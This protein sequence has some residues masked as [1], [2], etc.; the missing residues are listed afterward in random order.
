LPT[1]PPSPRGRALADEPGAAQAQ[2]GEHTDALL[3]TLCGVAPDEVKRLR[4][5]G[6]V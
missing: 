1:I 4:E 5:D 3:G 6:V 2:L